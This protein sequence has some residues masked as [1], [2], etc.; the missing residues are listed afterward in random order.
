MK[1][2]LVL[3]GIVA[4][5]ISLVAAVMFYVTANSLK[6]EISQSQMEAKKLE[7]ETVSLRAQ[8]EKIAKENEKLR[9]DLTS[10]LG[11][12]TRAKADKEKLSSLL[13][14]AQKFI[15]K[16]EADL[17]LLNRRLEELNKE[18]DTQKKEFQENGVEKVKQLSDKIS[19]LESTLSQE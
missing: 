3:I 9:D 19:S 16:K 7:E 12:D 17:Q 11:L 14:K 13:F 8:K 15:E 1:K 4:L 2:V 10:Y 6:L 18:S 5:V